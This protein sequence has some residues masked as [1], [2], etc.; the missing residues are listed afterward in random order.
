M[1]GTH[2]A[3]DELQAVGEDLFKGMNA[4]V[5]QPNH[6]QQR[7]EAEEDRDENRN[8]TRRIGKEDK[9]QKH[10]AADKE[11]HATMNEAA[12]IPLEAC[13]F[14]QLLQLVVQFVFF[15]NS[16]NNLPFLRLFNGKQRRVLTSGCFNLLLLADQ[17]AFEPVHV[18]ASKRFRD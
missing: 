12:R 4:L 10:I 14:E 7:Q 11:R 5:S 8:R 17:T 1:P 15:E 3:R 16:E 6:M 9:I 2:G 18:G 13:L